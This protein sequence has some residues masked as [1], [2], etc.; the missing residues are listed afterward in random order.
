MS[1]ILREVYFR[2]GNVRCLFIKIHLSQI[3]KNEASDCNSWICSRHHR[4][5]CGE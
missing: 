3:L 5:E 2:S 1:A 4:N